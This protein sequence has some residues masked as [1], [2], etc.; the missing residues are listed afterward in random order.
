MTDAQIKDTEIVPMERQAALMRAAT[1]A[2]VTVAAVLIA[3][4][5]FAWLETSSVSLLSSLMDSALDVLASLINLIA[6]H[7]SLTPADR[8]HRFGHGKVEALAGLGQSLF[9]AASAVFVGVQAIAR[10]S[11]PVA[12]PNAEIGI[13][14]M[15]F[16]MVVTFGLV[17]FQRYVARVTR[18]VAISADSM[19][20]VADLAQNAGVI[21]AIILAGVYG[22]DLA[23]PIIAIVLAFMIL[24]AAWSIV[25]A[26]YDVL[27]DRELPDADRARIREV[28]LSHAEVK[29]MHDLRTRQSGTLNFI[30]LHLELDGSMTLMEAHSISDEVEELLMVAF[31]GSEIIIHEDPEGIVERRATFA[32]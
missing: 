14:V 30:Q 17:Q 21:A 20:Y 12:L 19:H 27:M 32:P 25:R 28:V 4:K 3:G 8:Q 22:F 5:L 1:Y 23:D 15:I 11:N 6:V 18:S 9:V 13:S 10:F 31:P 7:R 2:S 26:A 16:S 29:D 24:Y